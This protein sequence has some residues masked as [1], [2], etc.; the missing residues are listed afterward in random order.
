MKNFEYTEDGRFLIAPVN[1]GFRLYEKIEVQGIRGGMLVDGQWD[2]TGKVLRD[3]DGN[4]LTFK[5]RFEA[6]VYA[7]ILKA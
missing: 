3:F 2:K 4:I 7:A 6:N 1:K 5:T